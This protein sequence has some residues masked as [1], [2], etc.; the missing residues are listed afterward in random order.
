MRS[1]GDT[2]EELTFQ[3]D[4]GPRQVVNYYYRNKL[5]LLQYQIG[6]WKTIIVEQKVSV[7]NHIN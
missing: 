3:V 7:A 1:E 2:F 5:L 4:N 6:V